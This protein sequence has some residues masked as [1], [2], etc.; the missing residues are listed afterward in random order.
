MEIQPDEIDVYAP[1]NTS[2]WF[3]SEGLSE[4]GHGVVINFL[5]DNEEEVAPLAHGLGIAHNVSM[6]KKAEYIGTAQ[7]FRDASQPD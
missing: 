7:D 1:G 3:A 4:T 2:K 6:H 5:A